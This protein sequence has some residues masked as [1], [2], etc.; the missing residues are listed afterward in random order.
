ME[1]IQVARR[2]VPVASSLNA[3]RTMRATSSVSG[4]ET[5]FR[6]SLWS[7]GAR[8]YR[9]HPPLPGRP[10]IYFPRARLAVFVHGCYWHRCPK[11]D[12]LPP[13]A[14]ADFWSAKFAA[15]ADRDEAAQR[16]LTKLGLE[17]VIVWEHDIRVDPTDRAAY[18]A[19]LVRKRLSKA[20]EGPNQSNWKEQA[21]G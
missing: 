15:N 8:G 18:L 6:R 11:C 17:V 2:I 16:A 13:V 4:L 10:D 5:R 7:A 21:Q 1:A 20:R 19:D 14:N 9:C 12:L 3:L